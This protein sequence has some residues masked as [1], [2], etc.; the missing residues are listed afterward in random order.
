MNILVRG[1][2]SQLNIIKEKISGGH[3]VFPF[4][5]IEE[6]KPDVI[7]D[8]EFAD[9]PDNYELYQTLENVVVLANTVKTSLAEF[10]FIHGPANFQFYGFNGLN[11]FVEGPELEVTCLSDEAEPRLNG[12]L[13]DLG[14]SFIVVED[15]V[16]MVTPRIVTMIINEAHYTVQE[17]TATKKDIDLGMKLGTNYPYGPFEWCDLI[18]VQQV[19]EI[20]EALYEDSKEERYKV[21]P[22][23]KKHYLLHAE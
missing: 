11:T 5:S 1:N 22:L 19:Y 8:F 13:N 9:Y 10:A 3:Q 15:R 23:L 6:N 14:I 12:L 18:G 21:A 2:E 16:G 20:L 7:F 4:E 17:G